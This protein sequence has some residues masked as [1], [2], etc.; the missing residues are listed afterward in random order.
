MPGSDG[1]GEVVAVGSHVKK[2]QISDRVIAVYYPN[3][4]H[5]NAPTLE[6]IQ[7]TPGGNS[8]GT[9]CYHDVFDESGLIQMPFNL[10]YAEAATSPCSALTAWNALHGLAPLKAGD[11]VVAQG[12]GGV[13]LFA[14][15]FA[16]ATGATVIAITS[17]T[18]KARKLQAMGVQH[19]LNYREDR[20]WGDSAKK[21]NAW[22]VR[23]LAC[24]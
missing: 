14:I 20:E 1:A 2:L 17:S 12:T 23:L 19:V 6:Q 18:E 8:P 21:P 5:G 11:Y 7:G 4:P 24:N 22:R 10:T 9:F 13:S 15:L 16:L 3:F